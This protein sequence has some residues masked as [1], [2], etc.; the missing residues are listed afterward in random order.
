MHYA[1]QSRLTKY[2]QVDC[3]FNQLSKMSCMEIKVFSHSVICS[4]NGLIKRDPNKHVYGNRR[5]FI[6]VL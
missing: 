3:T 4:K 1:M 6:N 2:S 5:N